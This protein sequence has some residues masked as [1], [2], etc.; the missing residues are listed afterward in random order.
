MGCW[1]IISDFMSCWAY[2]KTKAIIIMTKVIIFSAAILQ[3]SG[4]NQDT[5]YKMVLLPFYVYN[6]THI[7]HYT[8]RDIHNI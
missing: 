3:N 4:I 8:H 1:K 2:H 5:R 6:Y 7:R